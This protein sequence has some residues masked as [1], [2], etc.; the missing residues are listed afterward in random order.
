MS[1]LVVDRSHDLVKG[2]MVGPDHHLWACLTVVMATSGG[3]HGEMS[4]VLI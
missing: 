1:L 2:R 4:L 3:S